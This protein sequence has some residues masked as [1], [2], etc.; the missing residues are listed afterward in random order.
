M[1]DA[2]IRKKSAI[3]SDEKAEIKALTDFCCLLTEN[4]SL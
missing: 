3:L 2:N 4:G 1:I